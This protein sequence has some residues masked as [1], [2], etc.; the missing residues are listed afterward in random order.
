[1]V[2]WVKSYKNKGL[3]Y[4]ET[5]VRMEANCVC[6]LLCIEVYKKMYYPNVPTLYPRAGTIAKNMQEEDSSVFPFPLWDKKKKLEE[7]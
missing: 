7:K 5:L 3:G 4:N 2:M 6:P 1:M